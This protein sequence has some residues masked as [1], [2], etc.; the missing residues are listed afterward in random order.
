M[1]EQS[2]LPIAGATAR[3]FPGM[4]AMPNTPARGRILVVDDHLEMATTLTEGLVERGFD[5]VPIDSSVE[6]GKLLATDAFDALVTDLRMPEVDGFE[7]LATS[8]RT[9]PHRPVIVMTAY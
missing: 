2:S 9:A 5:A 7:L 4:S 6:A 3:C 8:R 1:S